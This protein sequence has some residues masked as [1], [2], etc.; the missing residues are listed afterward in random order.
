[1]NSDLQQQTAAALEMALS[2]GADDVVAN[3]SHGQNTGFTFRDHKLEQVQQSASRSLSLQLYVDGRYSSHHT[4]D[5]RPQEMRRLVDDAVGLTRHLEPDPH[6][7]IPDPAL[8]AGRSDIDLDL[9]DPAV[10]EIQ[11]DV[12]LDWL[13]IMDELNHADAR[14]I[15]ATSEVNFGL[16]TSVRISSNGFEG[17]Q[18]R[19][20][21]GYVS[22][23]SLDEGDGRRPEAYRWVGAHHLGDL[24]DP[25]EVAGESLQRALNR[26]GSTK[27]ASARTTMVV[28]REAGGGLLQYLNT[29]LSAGSIQQKRSFLADK[30]DQRI[31]SDLFTVTDQP[32]LQR[33]PSSR[34]YD[35]E[36]I[37]AR[38]MPICERGVLRSF[39]VDTYY[40][41]KLGW[42]PTTGGLSNIVF[43]LGDQ[44][45]EELMAQVGDGFHVDGWLGGNADSTTGNFSFG[46]QGHRIE[47]GVKTGPVSE[48]NITGNYLDL[49]AN[50][51]AVGN[52]PYPW[53]SCQTPTLVFENVEFSG[54]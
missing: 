9:V 39:Y 6:R 19:T 25:E 50:L 15:S 29:A 34:H 30:R 33:G 8:Y 41:R 24:P 31:A 26:L 40:G 49:L 37:T 3:T 23:V 4:T 47:G 13:G 44:G 5:L 14:V 38:P 16:H 1:M 51:A 45:E 22:S 42:E 52:D 43:D 46:I 35:G 18:E 48:M 7:V 32:L 28:D 53:S 10:H 11:R 36:G 17:T 27:A 21:V 54:Q 20:H 2:A 12:C